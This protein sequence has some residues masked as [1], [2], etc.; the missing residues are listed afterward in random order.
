MEIM[1]KQN[2]RWK[3]FVCRLLEGLNFRKENGK[4][5]WN[6]DHTHNKSMSI[7]KEMED[8]DIAKTMEYFKSNGAR[9]C[10]C[11]IMMNI[12]ARD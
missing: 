11:E 10:S 9:C 8:V 3:E 4:H 1:N 12:D 5:V 7:L 2:K 6:C